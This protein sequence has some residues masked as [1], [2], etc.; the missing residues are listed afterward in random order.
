MGGRTER[1]FVDKM[2][3]DDVEEDIMV[4]ME[5]DPRLSSE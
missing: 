3:C 4:D 1:L 2:F 5:K